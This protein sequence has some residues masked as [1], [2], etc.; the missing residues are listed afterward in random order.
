MVAHRHRHFLIKQGCTKRPEQSGTM[1]RSPG[2]STQRSSG[3]R[4]GCLRGTQ[5]RVLKWKGSLRTFLKPSWTAASYKILSLNSQTDPGLWGRLKPMENS[6]EKVLA[7]VSPSD[8]TIQIK[9]DGLEDT[10]ISKQSPWSLNGPKVRKGR[11]VGQNLGP[12]FCI[13]SHESSLFPLH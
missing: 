2:I 11:W 8:W 7:Q 1:T 10:H 5:C 3:T 12:G 4:V 6:L 13:F 9:G